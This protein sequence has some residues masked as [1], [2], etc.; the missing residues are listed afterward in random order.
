MWSYT[1]AIFLPHE[2][3]PGELDLVKA[4][5]TQIGAALIQAESFAN[6]EELNQQLEALDRT[7][8]NL[9]AIT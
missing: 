3:Q 1:I 9:I 2:W 7:R 6:L 8:S 4:I 5:A